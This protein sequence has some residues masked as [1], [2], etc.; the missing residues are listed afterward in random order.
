L[1]SLAGISPHST[2]ISV[3]LP[4]P[5]VPMTACTVPRRTASETRS[6]AF[7]PPKL[8]ETLSA[9]SST[10]SRGDTAFGRAKSGMAQP[11]TERDASAELAA[12]ADQP[13]RH[14]CDAGDD[15]QAERELPVA[16][17]LAEDRIGLEELLQQHEGEGA[18]QRAPQASDTAEDDHDQHRARLVPRQQLGVDEA[19]LQRG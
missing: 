6:T 13:L 19:V 4:A 15:R 14:Q 5:L 11:A 17:E 10:S 7:R 16:R 1:P 12:Q 18:E 8:R 3:D 9:R 2:L